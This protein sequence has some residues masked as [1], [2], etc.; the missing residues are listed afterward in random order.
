[1]EDVE[2]GSWLE[3]LR[4]S[5]ASPRKKHEAGILSTSTADVWGQVTL[6]KGHPVY[7]RLFSRIL[8]LYPLNAISTPQLG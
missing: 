4:G 8:G 7:C 2:W 6:V 3:P 5:W 1:M